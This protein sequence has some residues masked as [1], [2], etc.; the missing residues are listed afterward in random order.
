MPPLAW[1]INLWDPF[2]AGIIPVQ[3][4]IVIG[5][6]ARGFH[7]AFSDGRRQPVNQ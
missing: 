3:V 2:L 1:L 7:A 5:F 4:C 6:M